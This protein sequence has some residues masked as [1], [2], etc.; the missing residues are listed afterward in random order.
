MTSMNTELNG[1]GGLNSTE[2]MIPDE[3]EFTNED[4][5]RDLARPRLRGDTVYWGECVSAKRNAWPKGSLYL[6]MTWAPRDEDGKRRG[7]MTRY[8]LTVPFA[9]PLKPEV[10]IPNTI[11][12]VHNF[13]NA[14]YPADFPHFPRYNKADGTFVTDDGQVVDSATAKTL[15]KEIV[16]KVRNKIK[17]YWSNPQLLVGEISYFKVKDDQYREISELFTEPP[18]GVEVRL[19]DFAD[20]GA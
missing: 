7:P 15:E 9:N 14:L 20:S 18:P 11:G 10:K 1:S 17:E 3:I 12:F 4:V 8:K 5:T 19:S 16:T 2:S 6:E 13:L